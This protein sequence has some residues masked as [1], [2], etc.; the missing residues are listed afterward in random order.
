MVVLSVGRNPTVFARILPFLAIFGQVP[1]TSCFRYLGSLRRSPEVAWDLKRGRFH[2]SADRSEN[3]MFLSFFVKNNKKSKNLGFLLVE[4]V[5]VRLEGNYFS[6]WAR[7]LIF[8]NAPS[9]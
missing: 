5:S 3:I 2:Q 1:P 6:F 4:L 9:R 8:V 7:L